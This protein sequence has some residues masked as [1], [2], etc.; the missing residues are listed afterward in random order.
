MKFVLYNACRSSNNSILFFTYIDRSRVIPLTQTALVGDTAN[1]LCLADKSSSWYFNGKSLPKNVNARKGSDGS[2][3]T[4]KNAQ[5][6]NSGAYTCLGEDKN[7]NVFKENG[8]L[9]VKSKS[10]HVPIWFVFLI[11]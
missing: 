10:F 9:Q 11:P 6:S 4:I 1:F 7:S 2:K 3:L 5:L 8:F